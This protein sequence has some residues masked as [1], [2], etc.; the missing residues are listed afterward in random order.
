MRTSH[1]LRQH[2]AGKAAALAMLGHVI[3]P[4]VA[5]AAANGYHG[6]WLD[7]EHR[8]F[9]PREVQLLLTLCHRFDIDALVRP[10]TREH[11]GLYRYLE[12]GATGLVIPLVHTADEAR[13]LVRKTR[14]PP[15][16]DRGTN[17]WGLES[18][19]AVDTGGQRDALIAH[20]LR[21]TF[22]L[23]QI[24]SPEAVRNLDEILSVDG[25]DGIFVG[26]E[27]LRVR[28]QA[29]A[30]PMSAEAALDHIASVCARHHTL[31]GT[32]ASSPT[33]LRALRQRGANLL[34]WGVDVGIIRDALADGGRLL[35]ELIG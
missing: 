4:F 9:D 21:E 35:T 8:A 18:N 26:P 2:R 16:G 33:A 17:G 13:A 1:I 30:D 28:L 25:V 10:A 15:H 5:H 19:Y 14:F 7:L 31:W 34:L 12:D 32:M 11:A 20:A 27:D 24:E 6:V 23:V 29:S 3:P 22:L